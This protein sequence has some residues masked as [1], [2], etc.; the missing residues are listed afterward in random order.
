MA[1]QNAAPTP[2]K[3]QVTSDHPVAQM[4]R[5]FAAEIKKHAS[6]AATITLVKGIE[7]CKLA[8]GLETHAVAIA[9][10]I[11]D[12]FHADFS[13]LLYQVK[14]SVVPASNPVAT[15]P[16][17]AEKKEEAPAEVKTEPAAAEPDDA[18]T[19][20]QI[21]ADDKKQAK[22]DAAQARQEQREEDA[23]DEAAE[24]KKEDAEASKE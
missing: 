18:R 20:A 6:P 11:A 16:A 22:A 3:I 15:A 2:P 8:D 17:V 23:A 13:A 4:F 12:H 5:D 10:D 7:L 21:K 14:A 19:K 24:R 9:Q 1:T